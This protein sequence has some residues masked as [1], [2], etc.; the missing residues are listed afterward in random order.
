MAYIRKKLDGSV[1][2]GELYER[3]RALD[4]RIAEVVAHGSARSSGSRIRSSP[5]PRRG[6]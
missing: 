2:V 1:P 6:A 4:A 3:S 5:T